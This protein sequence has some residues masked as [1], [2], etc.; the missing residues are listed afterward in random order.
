MD[1]VKLNSRR[2]TCA[3]SYLIMHLAQKLAIPTPPQT[4]FPCFCGAWYDAAC[5]FQGRR[6]H[7]VL[8]LSLCDPPSLWKQ[9]STAP[10]RPHPI[11]PDPARQSLT[12]KNPGG[13]PFELSALNVQTSQRGIVQV[14]TCSLLP[15]PLALP[16]QLV[17]VKC[18]I[19]LHSPLRR[20]GQVYR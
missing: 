14:H 15:A 10:N 7:T 5:E 1:S 3:Y 4:P 8:T 18:L 11:E 16:A 12:F 9:H 13:P 17:I 6:C 19:W 20:G 2:R